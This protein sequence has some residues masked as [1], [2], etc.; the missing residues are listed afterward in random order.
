MGVRLNAE[1]TEIGSILAVRSHKHVGQDGRVMGL[2][3]WVGDRSAWD[4]E[5]RDREWCVTISDCGLVVATRPD[6]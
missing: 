4:A 6:F 1:H 3:V 5:R 2:Q